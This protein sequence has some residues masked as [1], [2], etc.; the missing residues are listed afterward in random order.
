MSTRASRGAAP[1]VRHDVER[2][3]I[4]LLALEREVIELDY[5]RRSDALER[6]RDAVRRLGEIGSPQGILERAAEEL[7]KSS[8]LDRVVISEVSDRIL[9]P[10]AIW[11]AADQAA[12]ETALARAPCSPDPARVPAARG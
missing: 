4:E 3:L 11:S 9:E 7:G 10:R 2:A 12:A 8:Q 1:P 6:V 5:V